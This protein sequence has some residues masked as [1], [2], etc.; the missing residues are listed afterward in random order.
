MDSGLNA[1]WSGGGGYDDTAVFD[2]VCGAGRAVGESSVTDALLCF[3]DGLHQ[4]E[5]S[6]LRFIH[7]W[8]KSNEWAGFG[9]LS[10]ATFLSS[11]LGIGYG[12]AKRRIHLANGI[13]EWPAIE[14]ALHD[15]GLSISQAEVLLGFATAAR[16]ELFGRDLEALIGHA[17]VL[18]H[19]QLRQALRFWASMADNEIA[20]TGN[21]GNPADGEVVVPSRL[22]VAAT[23]DDRVELSGSFDTV[24]GVVIRTAIDAA[25]RLNQPVDTDHETGETHAH[26]SSGSGAKVP[27]DARCES[28]RAAEALCVIASFFL[29]H[30][31][32]VTGTGNVVNLDVRIDLDTLNER[33]G[34]LAHV[35]SRNIGVALKDAMVL[36]CH[37]TVT[38]IVTAGES[39][40]VD[41]GRATRA[42]SPKLEKTIR[43]RD[44][45]CR[46]PGCAMPATFTDVHHVVWW[47]R[48][49]R[50][51]RN[52]LVLL[53][54][55]HH[56]MIHHDWTVTGDPNHTLTFT[57]PN[58]RQFTSEPPPT[59]RARMKIG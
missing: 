31:K 29:E 1:D 44:G 25:L 52:N 16:A 33:H 40:V 51:D 58:G 47:S 14:R 4:A 17:G 38:R 23:L 48:G 53:C 26:T 10:A 9:C 54:R 5:L 13:A 46:F 28:V 24:D 56:R 7:V 11:T 8:S 36:C 21:D 57:N 20:S 15:G 41:V 22:H 3:A 55:R 32:Q 50:T 12:E 27:G 30:H 59:Q 34:G 35:G 42:V 2:R 43:H 6:V 45:H 49:G 18:N 19:A 39:M 37:P